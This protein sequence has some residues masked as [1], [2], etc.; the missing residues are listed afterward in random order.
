VGAALLLA[1]LA[2]PLA[3]LHP[4]VLLVLLGAS[5]IV[6][7]VVMHP[8]LA[9]YLIL[10]ITPVIA[11][12]NRG[13]VVPVLRPSEALTA[14]AALGLL[15]RGGRVA[16]LRPRLRSIDAVLITLAA[17]GSVIPLL[18]MLA[19]GQQPTSDDL[20]YCLQLWKCY[21]IFAMV[22][23]SIRTE[24]QVMRAVWVAL[25]S[26]AAVALVAVPQS[27]LLF[28]IPDFLASHYGIAEGLDFASDA[29]G[30]STLSSSLGVGDLMAISLAM[31]L[32]LL[33]RGHA[34]KKLLVAL[35]V[36]F[37]FG[38]VAAGQFS[39]Y[40]AFV[41]MLGVVAYLVGGLGRYVVATFPVGIVAFVALWPVIGKRLSGFQS[42]SGLPSSWVGRLDNLK[43]FF[44]PKLGDFNWVLGVRPAGRVP[45]PE[46]WRDWVYI[47]SGWTWLLWT[48]G[49]VF[50]AAFLWFMWAA[51]RIAL[52]A[53][54]RGAG[55]IGVAGTGLAASLSVI[56]V[57][58]AFD[59][60]LTLRAISELTFALLAMSLLAER[61]AGQA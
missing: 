45:A 23:A 39:G 59:P 7:A 19:R 30:T 43:T 5:S 4:L 22:R 27:L 37:F 28:G 40:I 21:A 2:G 14:L 16:R 25:F 31:S 61:A 8:P 13:S 1:L 49:V 38:T 32:A 44:W 42:E 26:A 11:G 17:A 55:A 10:G 52:R 9:T 35:S 48:G 15:L 36:T 6:L 57:L 41:V 51:M 18:W 56:F 46:T 54:R 29:R 50:L 34:R 24:Q 33:L 58:M 12:M 47:E 3:A 60:H 53:A 20:L